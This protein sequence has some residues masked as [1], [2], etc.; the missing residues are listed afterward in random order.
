MAH[1]PTLP[2]DELR[3]SRLL[4]L[5]EFT[6]EHLGKL[7]RAHVLVLGAGGLGC[8]ATQALVA[9][10]IGS[11][12]WADAD[13]V[14]ASNL[15]RQTLFG[16]DDVGQPKVLAGSRR[17]RSL[18]PDCQIHPEVEHAT[19]I[20]L[21]GWVSQADIVL[22]C[23]DRFETRQL[24]NL[25]CMAANK[26]LAMASVIQWSGQLMLATASTG[27]YACV[28]EPHSKPHSEPHSAEQPQAASAAPGLDAACGAYGVFPTAA[29][30][31]GMLQ[32][33]LALMAL[34]GMQDLGGRF[35]QWDSK[36]LGMSAVRFS[37]RPNCPV[38]GEQGQGL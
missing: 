24:I 21:P 7:R 6:D 14:D 18:A 26:P 37:A 8:P 36:S 22:D 29:G 4:L 33:H 15:P 17:L 10:G 23:T 25:H 11:L 38:C 30:T 1:A 27:C 2:D 12:R 13:S 9:A 19:A 31:M 34:L 20:N 32:A 35:W 16:P 5:P 3:F 28:F